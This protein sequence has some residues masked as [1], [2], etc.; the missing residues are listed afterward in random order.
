MTPAE[1]DAIPRVIQLPMA[2]VPIDFLHIKEISHQAGGKLQVPEE[3][4]NNLEVLKSTRCQKYIGKKH[5]Y[6][7]RG[8]NHNVDLVNDAFL[9]S[10]SKEERKKFD[11]EKVK[12]WRSR[13]KH[14]EDRWYMIL[15]GKNGQ[16]VALYS[17]GAG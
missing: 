13:E 9:N 6:M 4:A 7:Y 3:G 16:K 15:E 12:K 5:P 14:V 1:E 8:Y 10:L 11:E 2:T 17:R